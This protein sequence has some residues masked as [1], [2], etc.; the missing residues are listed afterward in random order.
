MRKRTPGPAWKAVI[1]AAAALGGVVAAA[2]GWA[3]P[4]SAA[5]SGKE[6]R[7]SIATP[8]TGNLVAGTVQVA[9]A[10]D[11]AAAGRITALEL[12]VDELIYTS[13]SLEMA[14]PRGTHTIDWDTAQLRNGQHS[15]KV[16]ALAGKKVVAA[17]SVVV[18]VSNG[19]VDVVPPLISFYAPLDGQIVSGNVNIGV[20]ASDNDQVA[21][22]GLFV[23]RQLKMMKSHPPFQYSLDTTALPLLNGRGA[24]V[25]EAWAYDREQNRGVAKPVT[26]YVQNRINATPMQPDPRAPK[27]TA[28]KAEPKAA[29]KV[30]PGGTGPATPPADPAVTKPKPTAVARL[31]PLEALRPPLAAPPEVTPN[32]T[33]TPPQAAAPPAPQASASTPKETL[34][35]P[36]TRRVEIPTAPEPSKTAPPAAAPSSARPSRTETA[37]APKEGEARLE[38]P[39]RPAPAGRP[40]AESPRTRAPRR[41]PT[42]RSAKP[43]VKAP[44]GELKPLEI[45]KLPEGSLVPVPRTAAPTVIPPAVSTPPAPR[46]PAKKVDLP[47]TAGLPRPVA[48]K[49]VGT[50]IAAAPRRSPAR[51]PTASRPVDTPKASKPGRIVLPVYRLARLPQSAV[52]GHRH[53]VQRGDTLSGIARQYG[54]TPRSILVANG[55][56]GPSELHAGRSL[57]IPGTFTIALNDRSV[58]FDVQPRVEKGIAITP[59]RQI[60]EHTGGV[61]RYQPAEREVQARNASKEIKLK[62]GSREALVNSAVILMDR[63]A[64]LDSGRTMVPVKFMTE[65]LDLQAEYDLKTGAIYLVKK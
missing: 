50:A 47:P 6:A 54:V 10:F 57:S 13:Q 18:T 25:L 58:D 44:A 55:L 33:V 46:E 26:V 22:V 20:N 49:P 8:A 19:G 17:D 16:R 63:E 64:F 14:E 39:L 42:A 11:A 31:S 27:G 56:T 62:I 41:T 12:W 32:E 34:A 29:A 36:P 37:V 53:Q 24:L 60:F 48:S 2:P 21:L 5:R 40:T 4:G 35:P 28:G 59:F 23:N 30:E 7:I 51:R 43:K 38:V 65:A 15:L 9:V 1:L 61:V 3:A 52:K 45:A